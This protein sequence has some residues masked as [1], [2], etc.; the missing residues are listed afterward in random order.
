MSTNPLYPPGG[1]T[2]P[3]APSTPAPPGE[4]FPPYAPLDAAGS[5]QVPGPA[6]YRRSA[7]DTQWLP[8]PRLFVGPTAPDA[9]LCSELDVWF[10]TSGIT[11]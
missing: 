1:T 3:V 2:A 6:S 4:V 9:G 10:D 8:Q 7:D 11:P 5:L